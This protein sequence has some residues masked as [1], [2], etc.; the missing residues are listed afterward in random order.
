VCTCT[1]SRSEDPNKTVVVADARTSN[2]LVTER[3]EQTKDK[4]GGKENWNLLIPSLSFGARHAEK[5]RELHAADRGRGLTW[6]VGEDPRESYGKPSEAIP[7]V[8][9]TTAT[10]NCIT[11]APPLG[12]AAFNFIQS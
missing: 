12:L 2:G 3:S 7:W 6:A 4:N 10:V 9:Y 1:Q 5:Q 8:T 11:A